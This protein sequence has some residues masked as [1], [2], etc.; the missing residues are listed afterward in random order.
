MLGDLDV[1]VGMTVREI[2]TGTGYN[3][4]LLAHRLGDANVTT[5]EVD[6]G[7]AARARRVLR[8]AGLRPRVL[9]AD[10]AEESPPAERYDRLIATCSVLRVPGAWIRQC[11][12]G[13]V[14][15][16]PVSTLFGDGAIARLVVGGT[17]R[18]RAR[19]R[20]LP[21]SCGSGGRGT[22]PRP[23]TTICRVSGRVALRA[24]PRRSTRRRSGAAG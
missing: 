14:I 16:T 13:G 12:P 17:A 5:V 20:V 15:V 11:R 3:A 9:H 21:R 6:G 7:V 1:E 8:D 10:G 4:G 22:G 24:S 19:S 2:G 23:W 18:P